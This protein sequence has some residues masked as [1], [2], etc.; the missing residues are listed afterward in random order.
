M[1]KA[2]P[3]GMT[4]R[5]VKRSRSRLQ[6][7]MASRGALSIAPTEVGRANNSAT[8]NEP[9]ERELSGLERGTHV[10]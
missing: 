9:C 2:P 8:C 1:V 10:R 5:G 7:G 6:R 4:A 3:A